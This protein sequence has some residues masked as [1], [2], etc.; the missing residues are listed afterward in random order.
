MTNKELTD[1]LA[2][3]VAVPSVNPHDEPDA[4]IAGEKRIADV[5][6]A[7][8]SECGFDVSLSEREAGRPNL[9]AARGPAD[10]RRTL[11]LEVHLDTVGVKG[12]KRPPF[13]PRVEDGKLYGRGACDDKGP[14]ASAL[15]ALKHADL[16][17]LAG[18]GVRVV[19][20]GAMGEETGNIGAVRLVEDGLRAD[21]TIVLEPTELAV[22]HAH[23]GALW[24]EVEVRGRA[25]HG[26]HPEHGVNAVT[27]MAHVLR[28]LEER[29]AGDRKRLDHPL[30]GKPSL[31][32]GSIHGGTSVNI[33]PDRC[34]IG[35]D[36]RTLPGENNEAVLE[37][38]RLELERLASEGL[39]LSHEI[40]LLKE[41]TPFE[42]AVP[43]PLVDLLTKSCEQE[44]RPVRMEGAAWYS[45]AG[46]LSAVSG[47]IAVFGPGSIRQAH[48]AEEYIDLEELDAG[49]RIL[50]RFLQRLG[51]PG[52]DGI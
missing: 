10:A 12:M 2:Q 16:D 31:S 34:V 45:D 21:Q 41:G 19:F 42:T 46:P 43:S 36:R 14:M 8:L 3:L 13:E 35:V 18:A 11:L 52:P 49:G 20:A 39:I 30:L 22:I 44:G 6:A 37:A 40:R 1:L 32:V 33:V 27:G 50:R 47:E 9:L 25:A 26:S 28:F 24:F 5:V 38:V 4:R 48:T 29:I 17:R 7:Y 15:F 23:K 51:D